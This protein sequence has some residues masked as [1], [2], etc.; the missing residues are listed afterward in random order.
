MFFDKKFVS[1]LNFNFRSI[2]DAKTALME[3]T[4]D[5]SERTQRWRQIEVLCGFQI[6]N[7][8]RLEQT[9]FLNLYL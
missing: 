6:L 8:V 1:K 3:V 4:Q 7:S 9:L 2:L 5:L